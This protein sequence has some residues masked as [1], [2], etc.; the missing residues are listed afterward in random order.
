MRCDHS[1]SS[2]LS[3]Q[4]I[5]ANS[6]FRIKP[7][8]SVVLEAQASDDRFTIIRVHVGWP[9]EFEVEEK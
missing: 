1:W 6:D 8:V 2:R 7:C 4:F 3:T 5:H 9:A